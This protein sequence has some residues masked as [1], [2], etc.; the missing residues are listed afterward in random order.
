[1]FHTIELGVAIVLPK[2][3]GLRFQKQD[4][5]LQVIRKNPHVIVAGLGQDMLANC[6]FIM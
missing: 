2:N 5:K 6:W 4:G 3:V 1:M